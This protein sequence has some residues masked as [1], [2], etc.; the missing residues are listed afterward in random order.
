MTEI[1]VGVIGV[2]S[3]GELHIQAYKA[4]SDVEVVAI[5]D[6]RESR[7]REISSKYGIPHMY[8]D[9]RELCARNDI[10]AVSVV[11]PETLHLE[12]VLA[13]VQAKKHVLLEKPIA[14]TLDDARRIIDAAAKGGLHLMV[15]HILR[16][17]TNYGS[18]RREIQDGN[19]G[20]IISIHARR[21]RPKKLYP[22]YSRTHGIL[23]NS[24]HDIDLC[25]WYT[26]DRVRNVRAFTRNI[27]GGENP[28]INWSFLE[29]EGGALACIENHWLI[30]SEAGIMTNDAMQVIGSKAVADLHLVPSS[31]NVWREQGAESVN[32]TYDAIF[33]GRVW[34]AIKEEVGYFV[35]CVKRGK[36][37]T[38][39]TPREAFEALKVALALVQSSQ[40]QHDVKLE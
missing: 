13:A 39:L 32:V 30:P 23:E 1:G 37:P 17:E 3:F 38:I 31:L 12:P 21:N 28:D 10:E 22:A 36:P 24:I 2:G 15:G 5:S 11:T 7:L 16:F 8:R 9:A 34:G 40:E 33:A 29:F 26:Q 19:L 25:L 4:L 6:V 20:R 18:I 27:Q 35:D 14:T